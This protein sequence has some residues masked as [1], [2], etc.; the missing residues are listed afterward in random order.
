M[1]GIFNQPF[2]PNSGGGNLN[3]RKLNLRHAGFS[4]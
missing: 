4:L 1:H 2:I 3:I